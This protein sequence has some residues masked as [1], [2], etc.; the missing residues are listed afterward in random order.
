MNRTKMKKEI[1]TSASIII[2]ALF[3]SSV[4]I[5]QAQTAT[6]S[7]SQ[8]TGTAVAA[9]A[10]STSTVTQGITF[11]VPELGNCSNKDDCR[12]YCSQTAN[13]DACIAFAKAHG[14]MNSDEASKASS[15]KK[16]LQS[17]G[18]PGGCTT[19]DECQ[20]FCNNIANLDTCVSFAKTHNLSGNS[21]DITQA[22]KIADY[23]KSG[24][25]MPGGCTTK[26]SCESYCSDFSHA[27][28]CSAFAQ[29]AGLTQNTG[30]QGGIPQ[31]QFQKFL[32]LAQS[33]Q[34]PGG[35][36]S[37]DQCENYCS[38]SAH[39]AECIKFGQEIGAISSD[40]AEKLQKLGGKGPG[41]CASQDSCSAYC[42][43]PSHRDECIKFAGDNG[44]ISQSQLQQMKA[45]LTQMMMGISQMPPDVA[46][47]V[48]S[49]LGVSSTEDIQSSQS[50][51]GTDVIN[52]VHECFNSFGKQE[53]P[54]GAFQNMPDNVKSCLEQKLGDSFSKITSGQQQPSPSDAEVFRVCSE[55]GRLEN[56]SSSGVTGDNGARLGEFLRSAPP[57]VGQCISGK[58]GNQADKIASGQ[59]QPSADNIQSIK[60]C[61]GEFQ[62][63]Q[64]QMMPPA[65]ETQ[66][67]PQ[68]RQKEGDSGNNPQGNMMQKLNLGNLPP[69]VS[70]CISASGINVSS[71]TQNFSSDA[72]DILN[73]CFQQAQPQGRENPQQPSVINP[74]ESGGNGS[75]NPEKNPFGIMPGLPL[76]QN[77]QT[78][79]PDQGMTGSGTEQSAPIPQIAPQPITQPANQ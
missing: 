21:E 9:T 19:P 58:L 76:R 53:N 42:N 48:K 64:Q 7:V 11:P 45:G 34:T 32:E 36:K 47:C 49:T 22:Q 4:I 1:F 44:L 12:N 41:G 27:Q 10:A 23:I 39:S 26:D 68:I 15:F 56:A 66:A 69:A 63:G 33:G 31:G 24:G 78:I 60:Q 16:I 8:A 6:S 40:Q 51:P 37:K 30:V 61:F 77:N 72:R 75:A 54:Q 5:A 38:D 20:S 74:R 43:D 2:S 14:L 57:S 17:G 29:K 65:N 62:V 3:T 18:G 73:K 50:L 28:E 55:Q 25:Q 35:C 70:N 71:G 13:I 67:A 52:K 59:Q 46:T 79:A